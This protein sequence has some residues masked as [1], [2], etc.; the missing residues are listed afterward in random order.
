MGE[1]EHRLRIIEGRP[2]KQALVCALNPEAPYQPWAGINDLAPGDTA[3]VVIDT[4]PRTVLCAFTWD[5]LLDARHAIADAAIGTRGP[6][7]L[8]AGIKDTRGIS[9]EADR[10]LHHRETQ[11]LLAALT[12][13]EMSTP[14]GRSGHSSVAIAQIVMSAH[15][16]CTACHGKVILASEQDVDRLV[17]TASHAKVD[18]GSDWP[19]LLCP[20]CAEAMKSGGFTNV[21][22]LVFSRRPACPRCSARRASSISYG[23]PP[24][25]WAMNLAPWQG[26]GGCVVE[27]F[28][29]RW[30]CQHCGY[31]WA[32]LDR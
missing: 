17:H 32:F 26:L 1:S 18:A 2:W 23:R 31:G 3:V 15:S 29:P 21:V 22:D 10:V 14:M 27:P 8:L 25:D 19:A 6:L 4:D 11:A 9:L 30:R 5:A 20:G 16:S 24:N 12:T 13:Y 28:A 7:R